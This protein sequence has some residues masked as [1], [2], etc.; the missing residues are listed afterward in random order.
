M[1]TVGI[2]TSTQQL[3]CEHPLRCLLEQILATCLLLAPQWNE[4]LEDKY[5]LL[6]A[7]WRE[8]RACNHPLFHAYSSWPRCTCKLEI[9]DSANRINWGPIIALR[10]EVELNPFLSAF[11]WKILHSPVPQDSPASKGHHINH[12]QMYRFPMLPILAEE[13]SSPAAL[14]M[15]ESTESPARQ[16]SKSLGKWQVVWKCMLNQQKNKWRMEVSVVE[17]GLTIESVRIC[18]EF[19]MWIKAYHVNSQVMQRKT[20]CLVQPSRRHSTRRTD[21][22]LASVFFST[23]LWKRY[24]AVCAATR[25][26]SVDVVGQFS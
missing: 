20:P 12:L 18:L 26:T 21:L 19:S 8:I 4:V 24:I 22:F 7:T 17:S 14:K 6:D 13:V 1:K 3:R 5:A 11:S 15:G 2:K 10:I 16:H 9:L 25:D 23:H